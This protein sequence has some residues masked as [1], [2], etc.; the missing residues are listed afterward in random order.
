MMPAFADLA[1]VLYDQAMLAEGGELDDPATFVRRVNRLIV[2]G[3]GRAA[4]NH[5]ELNMLTPQWVAAE[6]AGEEASGRRRLIARR[7]LRCG[8]RRVGAG[9]AGRDLHRGGT[10]GAGGD[11]ARGRAA[12]RRARQ[13][14]GIP[15]YARRLPADQQPCRSGCRRDHRAV[16]RRHALQRRP[17]RQ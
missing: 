12:A 7:L 4:E 8:D 2:E 14:F 5:P 10:R 17:R 15:V 1:H 13:R 6:N 11:A 16:E 3:F 9:G